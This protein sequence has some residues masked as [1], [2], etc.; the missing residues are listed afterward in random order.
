MKHHA[1]AQAESRSAEQRIMKDLMDAFIAERFFTINE[2]T[3]ALLSAA[4]SSLR[5]LYAEDEEALVYAGEI[6]FLI[7]ESC[8]QGYQ[9]VLDSPIYQNIGDEWLEIQA[10]S[11]LAQIVLRSTLSEEAYA[12]PGVQEFLEGLKVSVEQLDLS[13]QR[14]ADQPASVP[15]TPY[16]WYVTGERIAS[17][18]DRPFHPLSKAKVGLSSQDYQQFM[19]EFAQPIILRWVAVSNH[20]LIKGSP[21]EEVEA[22][23]VLSEP[24][25]AVI[26]QELAEKGI[27]PNQYTMIPV[28]PWQLKN[29]ILP[30]YRTEIEDRTVVVL[31]AQAGEFLATSSVRSLTG[32][33][34]STRM[35]KLPLSVKSLGAARYLPVVKLLNGLAGEKMFRQAVACDETLA[36]RVF[37]CEEKHW[38]GYMPE[39]MGLFDDHPRHLA[40]QLRIYPQEIV[41]EGYKIIPMSALGVVLTNHSHLLSLIWGGSPSKAEVLTFYT[42]LSAI[43][44]DIVMRLFKVGIV[45]EIHGQNCCIVLK[46]NRITGLLFRDHDSVRLHQPYLDRHQIQDPGYHIRPGYSNSLYNETL[47]KLIFYVQSLGTQVNLA[48]IMEALSEAYE[49]PENIMWRITEAKLREALDTID[50]PEA[51]RK[52]LQ[53]V[54]FEQEEWPVKLIIRPLLEADGVPG[55]MPSGKGSGY[56]PFYSERFASAVKPKPVYNP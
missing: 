25:R 52:R 46:D 39:S 35:V 43:F 1:A 13:L 32:T 12:H 15:E 29:I 6:Y 7:Q 34:A 30:N 4:P 27:S 23:D 37:L 55:A 50:I 31:D 40:A 51:D 3:T 11:E 38:W 16:D 24:E 10:S 45:P 17:L 48:A 5:E 9:W 56:N 36:E 33:A 42:E 53:T 49:I 21:E 2:A 54:L 41:Q 8:K 14:L 18:R 22:L 44:Y 26:K 20:A 28:H 47:D 19:A